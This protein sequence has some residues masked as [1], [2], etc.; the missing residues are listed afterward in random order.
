LE[1]PEQY[2]DMADTNRLRRLYH[3]MARSLDEGIGNV[4]KAL[5]AA[6]MYDN[7][8]IFFSRY[9]YIFFMMMMTIMT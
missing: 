8:W 5:K 1:V 3:G 4:T 9:L 7:T 6:A 2:Q